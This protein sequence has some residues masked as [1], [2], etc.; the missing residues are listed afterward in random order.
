[1]QHRGV[2]PPPRF[3][4]PCHE[5]AAHFTTDRIS[6][7][8][9]TTT[10]FF[11]CSATELRERSR[12]R[13]DSNLRPADYRRSNRS[14][15]HRPD[16]DESPPK[17]RLVREQ[18][19]AALRSRTSPSRVFAREVSAHFTTDQILPGEQIRTVLVDPQSKELSSSPPGGSS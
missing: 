12:S 19:R 11:R 5:V 14:L 18:A 13:Q 2:E 6:A 3:R 9:L 17:L 4:G 16:C 7:G 1:M 10:V 15:R 8:E